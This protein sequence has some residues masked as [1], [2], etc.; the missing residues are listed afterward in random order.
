MI[1]SNSTT[2]GILYSKHVGKNI[3]LDI[4][5]SQQSRF[6]SQRGFLAASQFD[7][8]IEEISCLAVDSLS[9]ADPVTKLE[10][11]SLLRLFSFFQN[12][13]W[14]QALVSISISQRFHIHW[15]M[16]HSF[17]YESSKLLRWHSPTFK[18]HISQHLCSALSIF[19]FASTVTSDEWN[20]TV[21]GK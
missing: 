1:V 14:F 5:D 20:F 8:D 21:G 9:S 13:T 2:P 18:W 17:Y 19:I 7:D 6:F 10:K 3:P 12:S 15:Y 11:V 16:R 4:P